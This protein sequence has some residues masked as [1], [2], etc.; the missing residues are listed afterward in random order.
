MNIYQLNRIFSD[1]TQSRI[2]AHFWKCKCLSNSVNHLIDKLGTSQSNISKHLCNLRKKEV[3]KVIK[4][5]REKY[6]SI[7]PKWKKEWK[8]I[9]DVQIEN[10]ENINFIC[11]CYK[12]DCKSE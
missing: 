9:V 7:N 1:K 3:L 4:K 10:K 8:N 5:G 11:S 6:Y 12:N 2:I